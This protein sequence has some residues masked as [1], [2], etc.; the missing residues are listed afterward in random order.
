M[1]ERRIL[2]IVSSLDD[3]SARFRLAAYRAPFAARGVALEL[4][5]WPGGSAERNA[6]IAHAAEYD[7]VVLLRRLLAPRTVRRLAARARRL[8]YEFDDAMPFRDSARGATKSFSRR[9]K[10]DAAVT[11]ADAVVAGNPYLASLVRGAIVA[12]V[13]T[14]TALPSS[15][16]PSPEG[17]AS[18]PVVGW[19]GTAANYPYLRSVVEPL[20]AAREAAA[21]DLCVMAERA[22]DFGD[23]LIA[24]R[25]WSREAEAAFLAELDVGIMPL[26]DDAWCRGKC[27]LKALQYMAASRPVV[28]SAVS[29]PADVIED[30]GI[31]CV[32]DASW[33][34]AVV[35]LVGDVERRRAM[36][37]RGRAIV[38]E[39]YTPDAWT[40]RLLA[41]YLGDA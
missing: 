2:G 8:I 31:R 4:R 36:G 37:V 21:F 5:A 26:F 16:T 9:R 6:L 39:G 38:R 33:R 40:D 30:A 3:P 19:V 15:P 7:A 35:S 18:R 17:P 11:A 22:P 25:P 27:G 34:Q 12:I 23:G 1:S 32:D 10:F 13:P 29:G 24:Y 14:V 41:L 28:A 20:A